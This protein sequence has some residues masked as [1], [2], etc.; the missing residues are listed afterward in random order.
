M[1]HRKWGAGTGFWSWALMVYA[2]WDMFQTVDEVAIRKKCHLTS[3]KPTWSC[4]FCVGICKRT[5]ESSF[6][7]GE[8]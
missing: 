1:L 6:L 7:A 3:T 8:Q 5:G 4:V 2:G